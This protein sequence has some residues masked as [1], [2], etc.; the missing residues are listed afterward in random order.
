MTK[1]SIEDLL[2]GTLAAVTEMLPKHARECRVHDTHP[3]YGDTYCD[4]TMQYIRN[5]TRELLQRA[6]SRT[7][8]QNEPA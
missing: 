5:S 1:P 2:I 4:C 6:R 8:D 3:G 7:T